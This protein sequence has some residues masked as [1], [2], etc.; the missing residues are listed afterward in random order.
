M[1]VFLVTGAAG[2]VGSH[3][4]DR[5]LAEGHEVV[6]VDDLSTGRVANLEQ[7]RARDD[8][9]SFHVADVRGD[10]LQKILERHRPQIVMHLA[11]QS[12]VRTSVE[13]P[14]RDAETNIVGL[15]ALMEAAVATR[16]RKIVFASSGGTIYGEQD[17]F[18]IKEAASRSSTPLSP[19]A[20]SKRV[21]QDYLSF[22]MRCRGVAFTILALGN[23]YGP[24]Q[25]P[26]GEAGVVSIFAS[27][28][29]R[30]VAPTIFGTGEQTRDYVFIDDVVEAFVAAADRGA[31]LLINTGTARE[32]SVNAVYRTLAAITGFTGSPARGPLPP[33]EPTRVCLDIE[34][35]GAEL[36]WRPRTPLDAGLRA[37]VAY[38]HDRDDRGTAAP[39]AL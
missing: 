11:A 37:T 30:G 7:A 29:M 21:A 32:T 3:L 10:G 24:R 31:G 9:F 16:V 33:G 25:D 23:V 6:G 14:R 27:A 34:L 38:L 5:L 28:M 22:Y 39:V 36:G 35:A 20:I 8:R 15:L 19:Y 12:S 18:P 26:R 1:T 13:D 2:F 17:V 4:C